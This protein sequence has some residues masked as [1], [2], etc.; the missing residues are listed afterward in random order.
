MIKLE[1]VIERWAVP[2]SAVRWDG[3]HNNIIM[4]NYCGRGLRREENG[5]LLQ[6]AARCTSV[7]D[8]FLGIH[9]DLLL[10]APNT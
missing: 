3:K 5:G 1:T 8:M 6:C 10:K 9:G 2:F 4:E 7:E